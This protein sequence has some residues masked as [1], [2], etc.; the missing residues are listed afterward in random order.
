MT[1]RQ[2]LSSQKILKELAKKKEALLQDYLLSWYH[3]PWSAAA[4][5]FSASL[6]AFGIYPILKTSMGQDSL[7]VGLVIFTV[8]L[9]IIDTIKRKYLV[10]AYN[11]ET[12]RD[13]LQTFL[14]YTTGKNI[15]KH[16]AIFY[17]AFLF[18]LMFD[19]LGVVSSAD[20][21]EDKYNNSEFFNT[22]AYQTVQA[23]VQSGIRINEDYNKDLASWEKDKDD[24]A[25]YCKEL[26][27]GW[28]AKYV[29]MCKAEWL[30]ANPKPI[31]PETVKGMTNEDVKKI[32]AEKDSFLTEW[33]WWII[34]W[35]GWMLA[36][37]L[38]STTI[39]SLQDDNE[40]VRNNLTSDTL[41]ILQSGLT[42]L[43]VDSLKQAES[44]AK[45]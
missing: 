15:W 44:L 22:R 36:I 39:S 18:T 9:M 13:I 19:T 27:A 30:E 16:K 8:I 20:Y 11:A 45:D 29:A 40:E 1:E 17:F 5:I 7:A 21:L 3:T 43:T 32:E 26:K 34:F 24:N 4:F 6:S 38:Q 12:R 2:D 25:Q 28:K 31:R 37:F 33:I 42:G 14:P 10:K 35:L 41:T 23:N